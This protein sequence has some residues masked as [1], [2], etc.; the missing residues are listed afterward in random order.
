MTSI[1]GRH[2]PGEG[3]IRYD[4]AWTNDRLQFKIPNNRV[5]LIMRYG[6]SAVKEWE[7]DDVHGIY[8]NE[9][10]TAL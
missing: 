10:Q 9:R 7:I 6:V 2:R 1:V 3:S 4:C 8:T 5:W